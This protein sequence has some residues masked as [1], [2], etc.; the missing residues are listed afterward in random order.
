MRVRDNGVGIAADMLTR[1]FEPFV[2]S[3]RVLH[4]SEGGLGIGLT[5]V[6]SLVEMHGGSVTAHSDG[7]GK[8][9]EFIV[10]LPALSQKQP[11]TVAKTA[12]EEGESLGAVPQ[13]RILVVDDNVDAAE[14]L[15]MLLR[16]EGHDV[17][18]AH[19]GPA[20]LAAIDADPPDLV[21]LDIGMPV[22]SGYEVAQRLRQ[23]PG[24]QNLQLVAMT[25]WGQEED[26][27]RSQEA[28]FDQH[29][30]KPVELDVLRKLLARFP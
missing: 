29:L 17:R 5:L 13:R 18:V 10:R 28:G 22:M 9:S 26:R 3:D 15:A 8:G 7:Q 14:S 16:T 11:V 21:F 12:R 20:A 1:I 25:G 23:R 19:D 2:Q 27:R 6:R 4:H 24:L 30:V